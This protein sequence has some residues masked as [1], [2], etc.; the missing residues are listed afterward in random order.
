[1]KAMGKKLKKILAIFVLA[2]V[3]FVLLVIVFISPITKYLIEKYSVKYTGR[4]IKMGWVYVNPFTGHLHFHNLKIYEQNSDTVELSA[5]GL[6]VAFAL[7][8]LF[9]HIYEIK[10]VTLTRP[11]I[12]VV[13]DGKRFDFSDLIDRFSS[14]GEPDTIP[15]APIR[16]NV[17]N[18]KIEGGEFHYIEQMTP[19]RYFVT[20]V[21]IQSP[22]KEW[23][24]DTMRFD[25]SFQSGPGKGGSWNGYFALNVRSWDYT[26]RTIIDHFDLA[27]LEQYL[28]E[29]ANYGTFRATLDA[30]V[31]SK[32]NLKDAEAGYSTGTISVNDFHVGKTPGEDYAAFDKA[33]VSMIKVAPNAHKYIFDSISL[34]HPFFVYEQY[35]YLD[36]IERMFGE[37]GSNVE[38]V[39]AN[40]EQV[41][42]IIEIARYIA[43]VSKN[44]FASDFKINKVA[45]YKGD[46]KFNDYS[47]TEEF[48]AE[49]TPL[50]LVSDSIYKNHTRVNV[51]IYSGIKPYGS[52][53]I[54]LSINPKNTEDFDM[55][56]HLTDVPL[57][58]FNPYLITYTSFPFDRGTLELQGDWTVRNNNIQSDNHVLVVDPFT[59][60]RLVKN[61]TKWLPVPLIMAFVRE[62][63][64]VIDYKIP[65]TG[66]LK[67]P[68]F[69]F[70][71]VLMGVLANIFIKPPTIP[72][73]IHVKAT[74]KIADR[75]VIIPWELQSSSLQRME[76]KF[77]K[78]IAE[79]LKKYPEASIVVKPVVYAEREKEYIVFY[80][81]KKKY[82][83][84]IHSKNQQQFDKRDSSMVEKMSNKDSA[85]VHYLNKHVANS[86]MFTI[87]EK[88][89]AFVNEKNVQEKYNKLM[90]E[91]KSEFISYFENEGVAN[92]V[93]F[94]ASKSDVPYDGLSYYEVSYNGAT[95]EE[96]QAAFD[97]MNEINTDI[98]RKKYKNIRKVI[99]VKYDK[100]AM[101]NDKEKNHK[102]VS[103]QSN[104]N[105]LN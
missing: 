100:Q 24:G 92:R 59:D 3:A 11:W 84:M 80:E 98:F 97:E 72:L 63:G 88:C 43:T 26:L 74:Q 93:K 68:Q 82:F 70:H 95:P 99:Q 48:S 56:Y 87:Q 62:R 64:N 67:K 86:L 7:R 89:L 105:D 75:T 8:K 4:Q 60:H 17:Y 42:V 103:N 37:K 85:F 27:P 66:T 20:K 15:T 71:Y 45:V 36:N 39:K 47:T 83:L 102:Y 91:R 52:A 22:G 79:F 25:Y 51:S 9:H 65:I 32:G 34:I 1:M 19:V 55:H 46:L 77:V 6:N 53:N 21:D 90:K 76:K 94:Y 2:L 33:T 30:N 54:Y 104:A 38:A 40:P 5:D 96:L 12:R 16:V 41:N 10:Y 28:K 29:F 73:G 81:A 101:R 50:Y 58:M 69:H 61:D 31:L 49:T 44:F 23:S 13:K 18:M 35:D 14:K 57:S 78:K